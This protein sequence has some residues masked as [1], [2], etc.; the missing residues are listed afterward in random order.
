MSTWKFNVVNQISLPK[1][2]KSQSIFTVK[3]PFL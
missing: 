3:R 2:I 1:V